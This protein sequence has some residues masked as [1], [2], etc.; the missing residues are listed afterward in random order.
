MS[1]FRHS[2]L[3]L[4]GEVATTYPRTWMYSFMAVGMAFAI[5]IYGALGLWLGGLF[6]HPTGGMYLSYTLYGYWFLTNVEELK[7]QVD[8]YISR[9]EEIRSLLDA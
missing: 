7:S 1:H 4:V 9:L 5:F 2:F 6:G 8:F 3:E